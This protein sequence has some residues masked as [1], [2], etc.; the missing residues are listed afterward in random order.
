MPI[1]RLNVR[2]GTVADSAKTR[3][4]KCTIC[5]KADNSPDPVTPEHSRVGGGG[6]GG[7]QRG[8]KAAH[9][10]IEG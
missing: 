10:L 2:G 8:P 1:R 6:W 5:G 7:A 9:R 4:C 3:G